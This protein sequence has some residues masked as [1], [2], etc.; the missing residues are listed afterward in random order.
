MKYF[1]NVSTLEE[2]RRQYKELLKKYHP[3]NPQGST[4]ACQDINAEYDRLFKVLKDKHESK[5]D[6][7]ADS[8]AHKESSYNA[9]MYDWENDKALREVLQK[10]INFDGIEIEIVGAWIWVSGNTYPHKDELK[11]IGFRWSKQHSKWHWHNG[12]FKKYGKKKLSYSEIKY[13]YG[14][15]KVQTDSRVLLE[16]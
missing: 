10:I 11:T 2:L 14:S 5:S 4:E 3:D 12:E 15:T 13:K 7:T 9:N 6:K 16:A 8:T 1:N